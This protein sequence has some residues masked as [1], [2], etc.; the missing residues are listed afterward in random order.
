VSASALR[1][2]DFYCDRKSNASRPSPKPTPQPQW[3]IGDW[4]DELL[5]ARA[6][7]AI[8]HLECNVGVYLS[9]RAI[10]VTGEV[11]GRWATIAKIA[12][13]IGAK[14]DSKGGC[15]V[16]SRALASLQRA[17]LLRLTR[18]FNAP[19]DILLLQAECK[20]SQKQT[21]SVLQTPSLTE[22]GNFDEERA[23][24]RPLIVLD[25]EM[26]KIAIDAKVDDWAIEDQFKRFLVKNK[27]TRL[28]NPK[29]AWSGFCK[30]YERPAWLD[31]EGY[32]QWCPE[33]W[34]IAVKT[35]PDERAAER[36]F[37]KALKRREMKR[38]GKG[39]PKP[40]GN[41]A[42]WWRAVCK[43]YV[44]EEPAERRQKESIRAA[45][46]GPEW[47]DAFP[48]STNWRTESKHNSRR[49]DGMEYDAWNGFWRK[50]DGEGDFVGESTDD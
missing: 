34:T 5:A 25:D 28:I 42:G 37:Y 30:K 15:S 36:Y 44:P 22:S 47:H 3:A 17:G 7:G 39:K 40:I 10:N 49:S 32:S 43:A 26:R 4:Q 16:V 33:L 21:D 35:F 50:P 18:R 8:T 13:N 41:A 19:S 9:R 2:S 27:D 23:H 46:P 31:W 29:A 6:R 1:V 11:K 20:C 45:H 38:K 14:I 24:N 12:S 48:G